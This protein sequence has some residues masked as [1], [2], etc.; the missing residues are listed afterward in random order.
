MLA[1]TTAACAEQDARG[2]SSA[3]F[4]SDGPA[5]LLADD[6]AGFAALLP[7]LLRDLGW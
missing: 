3:E 6:T 7:T 5:V 4:A 1:P 2:C